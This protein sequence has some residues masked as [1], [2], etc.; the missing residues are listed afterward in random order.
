M[1]IA[2]PSATGLWLCAAT[3]AAAPAELPVAAIDGHTVEATVVCSPATAQVALVLRATGPQPVT[4]DRATLIAAPRRGN[5]DQRIETA[6]AAT[7]THGVPTAILPGEVRRIALEVS[8][9]DEAG[10]Y[11]G[12]VL[13]A[14][15]ATG[16]SKVIAFTVLVRRPWW[17]ALGLI[18]AGVIVSWVLRAWRLRGRASASIKRDLSTLRD[19]V[20][21]LL[22]AATGDAE[23]NAIARSVDRIAEL[24]RKLDRD[25]DT[26]AIG[27]AVE[28][29]WGQVALLE[30]VVRA[31]R[32]VA[33]LSATVD[34]RPGATLDAIAA[35]L[36]RDLDAAAL[37]A[38]RDRLRTL[39]LDAALHASVRELA[40]R[41]AVRLDTRCR[42]HG[43]RGEHWDAIATQVEA[44]E[45]SLTAGR[46]L[47]ARS[48]L[49][50]A[51]R[52]FSRELARLLRALAAEPPPHIDAQAWLATRMDVDR[53]LDDV[54]ATDNTELAVRY[55]A[56]A[57]AQFLRSAA[58]ALAA[59]ARTE[60]PH[61]PAAAPALEDLARRAEALAVRAQ[62]DDDDAYRE[63]VV[64]YHQRLA[65]TPR[66]S[67]LRGIQP[68]GAQ[69]PP[70]SASWSPPEPDA[71]VA[72]LATVLPRTDVLEA[73]IKVRD[74]ATVVALFVLAVLTGL[75][76]LWVDNATWGS[77]GDLLTG[78][79]W[80]GG[81]HAGGEIVAD[82]LRRLD[83]RDA[84]AP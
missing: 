25:K 12:T 44:A 36:G 81:V 47:E 13:V 82:A 1:R 26:R 37:G 31:R 61:R 9:L 55:H 75:R 4:I 17:I 35:A 66:S 23:H 21:R 5:G 20:S 65:E 15:A 3:S 30:D 10:R 62:P 73:R 41:L 80:G 7:A 72:V 60:A 58:P 78:L 16:E 79:L 54:D 84:G 49:A 29:L 14:S 67:E 11:E 76:A 56:C 38:E 39:D 52:R 22:T 59:A 68:I 6:A 33:L 2:I 83:P 51:Y 50:S 70:A 57:A 19:T 18:A 24:S 71:L 27:A 32:I 34:P 28:Q 77:A 45:R 46:V 63:L 53:L 40:T 42:V 43:D 69:P 48:Q 74:G 8:G 64:E